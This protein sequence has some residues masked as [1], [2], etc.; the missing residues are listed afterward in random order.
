MHSKKPKV[1]KSDLSAFFLN[2]LQLSTNFRPAPAKPAAPLPPG[3]LQAQH[4]IPK[5]FGPRREP[6]RRDCHS[7]P[8]PEGGPAKHLT[9]KPCLSPDRTQ[10]ISLARVLGEKRSSPACAPAHDPPLTQKQRRSVQLLANAGHRRSL[11]RE[12]IPTR[13]PSTTQVLQAIPNKHSPIN[14]LNAKNMGA[15][16]RS[17]FL[18]ETSFKRPSEPHGGPSQSSQVSRIQTKREFKTN[19]REFMDQVRHEKPKVNFENYIQRKTTILNPKKSAAAAESR[20]NWA[21]E[22]LS[23][24]GGLVD[25]LLGARTAAREAGTQKTFQKYHE[26]NFVNSNVGDLL[27]DVAK[28]DILDRKAAVRLRSGKTTTGALELAVK[29][30]VIAENL[31]MMQEQ[32]YFEE[33]LQV[34]AEKGVDVENMFSYCNQRL[35][36]KRA[37]DAESARKPRADPTSASVSELSV[38]DADRLAGARASRGP[39][40]L[41]MDFT[42]LRKYSSSE[43]EPEFD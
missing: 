9:P 40:K 28:A 10:K 6:E 37:D 18:R 30:A 35:Q 27:R 20:V 15:A 3:L 24:I 33:F 23:R 16:T 34:L 42:K 17:R 43:S 25:Q 21:Q 29:K 11:S 7:L 8:G 31:R 1:T 13:K 41:K 36:I 4:T 12:A 22:K 26:V 2:C 39:P 5:R 38:I 14:L 19:F 32:I